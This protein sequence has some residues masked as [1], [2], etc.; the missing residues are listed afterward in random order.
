MHQ[1]A[2]TSA[3][4]AFDLSLGYTL[5]PS[6]SSTATASPSDSPSPTISVSVHLPPM[7]SKR[8][9]WESARRECLLAWLPATLLFELFFLIRGVCKSFAAHVGG[10]GHVIF[11]SWG[12]LRIHI[13]L[14]SKHTD[15]IQ[16]PVRVLNRGSRKRWYEKPWLSRCP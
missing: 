1:A 4:L 6:A 11:M 14:H 13:H 8:A 3:D 2:T 12:Q 9:Y 15:T 5:V 16:A 7:H 10:G